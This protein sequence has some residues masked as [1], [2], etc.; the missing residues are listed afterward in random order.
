MKYVTFTEWEDFVS[1]WYTDYRCKATR[2]SGLVDV[3]NV[4]RNRVRITNTKT[5]KSVVAMCHKNDY[6][7]EKVGI[8]VAWAKYNGVEIPKLV[9]YTE[10]PK[11]EAMG[12]L[13]KFNI[14]N[15]KSLENVLKNYRNILEIISSGACKDIR[16]CNNDLMDY[17]T[18]YVNMNIREHT[19][20]YPV[21][22]ENNR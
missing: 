13:Q 11:L 20:D 3:T 2:D 22:W 12:I 5:G 1:K 9:N 16:I 18:D 19:A 6:F 14:T 17:L 21:R 10:K 4:M 7:D 8:A 15:S